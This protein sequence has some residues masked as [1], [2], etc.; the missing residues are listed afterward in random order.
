MGRTRPG[1]FRIFALIA[2]LTL[3]HACQE[4]EQLEKEAPVLA[5]ANFKVDRIAVAGVI[6]DVAA[7]GD[8]AASREIWSLQIGAHLGRDRFGKLPIVSCSEVRAILGPDDYGVM[9]DRYKDDGQCDSVILADLHTALAGKARFIVFGS[10]QDDHTERSEKESEDEKAKTKSKT[11]TTSRTSSVR[12]RFYDL[13]DQRLV[14]DHLTVGQ[15]SI[16]KEH[17]MT[18]VI[19]HSRKEGFLGGLLTSVANS[20]MKPD[21]THPPTPGLEKSLANAFDNVGEY[22]KP[23]KHE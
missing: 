6:S 2:A 13:S 5:R 8:S 19:K 22:L 20:A 16:S 10:I 4:R 23:R 17:D 11:M 14:W 3:V 18:D 12:L 9:L 7:L 15:S 21:P 1:H